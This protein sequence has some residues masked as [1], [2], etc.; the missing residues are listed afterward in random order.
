MND[1]NL[2]ILDRNILHALRAAP[3]AVCEDM[4]AMFLR[5]RDR[6]PSLRAEN[7]T[8]RYASVSGVLAETLP[9]AADLY[10]KQGVGVAVGEDQIAD[11]RGF[12]RE[13]YYHSEYCRD[14]ALKEI[15]S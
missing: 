10:R 13:R 6:E 7:L 11:L 9:I 15:G 5:L 1:G 4:E 14:E 8:Y 2:S 3:D 12:F